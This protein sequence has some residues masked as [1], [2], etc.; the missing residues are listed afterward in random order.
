MLYGKIQHF[1]PGEQWLYCIARAHLSF[2]EKK[3]FDSCRTLRRRGTL[4]SIDRSL[5]LS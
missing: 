3:V 1:S 2:I 5:R 4:I